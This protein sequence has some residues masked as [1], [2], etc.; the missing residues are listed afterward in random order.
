MDNGPRNRQAVNNKG[1]IN[2]LTAA[3]IDDGVNTPK[4]HNKECISSKLVTYWGGSSIRYIL[5]QLQSPFSNIGVTL[6]LSF[7][8]PYCLRSIQTIEAAVNEETVTALH[9]ATMTLGSL[10]DSPVLPVRMLT[11][12]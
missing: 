3:A 5:V 1:R 2:T 11:K 9:L 4:I 7:H 8:A 12:I 6:T 10:R